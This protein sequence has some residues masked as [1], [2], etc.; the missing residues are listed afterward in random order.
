MELQHINDSSVNLRWSKG[1]R[2]LNLLSK[3]QKD[4]N[5]GIRA[6]EDNI[7][8]EKEVVMKLIGLY[9]QMN[10]S[11]ITKDFNLNKVADLQGIIAFNINE[12]TDAV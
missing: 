10:A 6:V 3:M 5:I 9:K 12:L 11:I 8:E 1:R 4:Q 2:G 7:S